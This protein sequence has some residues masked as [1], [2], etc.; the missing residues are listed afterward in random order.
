MLA[1]E[2]IEINKD[3]TRRGLSNLAVQM[4]AFG[5]SIGTDFPLVPGALPSNRSINYFCV[6]YHWYFLLFD[7]GNR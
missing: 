4:I 1:A 2:K 5:G 7:A 6:L 3:G